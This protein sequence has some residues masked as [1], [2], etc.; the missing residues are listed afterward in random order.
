MKYIYIYKLDSQSE[1]TCLRR[2]DFLMDP[3]EDSDR[4]PDQPYKNNGL[5]LG[6]IHKSLAKNLNPDCNPNTGF[7][8]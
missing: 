2:I 8:S 7:G 6:P 3:A 4:S 5:F 1:T